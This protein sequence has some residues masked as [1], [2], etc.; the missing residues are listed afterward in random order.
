[1]KWGR[2]G[3]WHAAKV[4]WPGFE[5][6]SAAFLACAPTTWLPALWCYLRFDGIKTKMELVSKLNATAAVWKN[7]GFKLN[8]HGEPLNLDELACRIC[9][10][11]VAT[12]RGNTTNMH[13]HLSIIIMTIYIVDSHWRYQNY[14]WNH[15]VNQKVSNNSNHVLN[16]RF[17]EI[18]TLCF[19]LSLHELHEV[20]TWNGFPTV[21]KEFPEMLSTCWPFCLHSV[22]HL[23]P[24]H[25]DWV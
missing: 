19:V 4:R 5:A 16:S 20:I 21:L 23:I 8:D 15:V 10:E 25:L 18:A 11:T 6:G 14:E 2:E 13:L 9:C 22:V 12:K 1:M 17:F 24:N 3:V 7:F